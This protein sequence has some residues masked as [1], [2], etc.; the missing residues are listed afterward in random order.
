MAKTAMLI[1]YSQMLRKEKALG[2]Q[3]QILSNFKLKGYLHDFNLM[4]DCACSHE[5]TGYQ[6]ALLC[7]CAGI[8][9][10]M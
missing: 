10:P 6:A 5:S 7:N 9:V 1:D 4:L 8:V 3:R 2:G